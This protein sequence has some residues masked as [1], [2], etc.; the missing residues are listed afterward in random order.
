MFQLCH[1]EELPH[2]TEPGLRG[3]ETCM[4]GLLLQMSRHCGG[5][6]QKAGVESSRVLFI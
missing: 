1:G 6:L 5:I 3:G 2:L 4:G